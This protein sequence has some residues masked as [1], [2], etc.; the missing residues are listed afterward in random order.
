[1]KVRAK[2]PKALILSRF[3]CRL[4]NRRANQVHL[5]RM[6]EVVLHRPPFLVLT[7][8]IGGSAWF[9]VTLDDAIKS[10]E[11]LRN[12]IHTEPD[13][14]E[15]VE[16][17]RKLEGLYHHASTHA[18]GVVIGDRP[19][20][21]LIPVY[22]DPR[23]DMPVTGFNMK[24]VES[25]GLVKFDFLG[26][27]TLSVLTKAE[28][29]VNS[30]R[31][32]EDEKLDLVTIPL[33]DQKTFDMISRG[34]TTVVDAYLSPI[35]RRYV[36][37]VASALGDIRLMFMQSSVCLVDAGLFHGHAY[38]EAIFG[39]ESTP[40]VA[41]LAGFGVTQYA[42]A[43]AAGY[44]VYDLIGKGRNAFENVPARVAGGMVAGAG[45]LLVGEKTLTLIGLG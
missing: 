17:A 19:L 45:A 16:I 1:M 9:E 12:L 34:D 43:I 22:R 11:G 37:Q 13:V 41:Y 6:H 30:K 8:D 24:F 18:A 32:G 2:K 29:F 36:D 39:A 40:L 23:S 38:G 44:V 21:E 20:E 28:N 10:E 3:N 26:L 7:Q 15:M 14:R 33:D 31:K 5:R 27:K 25:A 35:L 4:C 42:I